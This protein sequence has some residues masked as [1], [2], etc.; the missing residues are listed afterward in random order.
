MIF[1]KTI[2][3]GVY[4]I[5]VEPFEDHRG[6][7]SRLYCRNEFQKIGLSKSLAQ[8][9]L[10]QTNIRGSVRGLHMQK[11][12]HAEV[13]IVRCLRG[14]CFDV[15]VDMRKESPTYLQWHGEM[16]SAENRR[17]LFIPEGFAHG[18]QALEDNTDLMYFVSEFYTPGAEVG[19]RYN[20]PAIGIQWPLE[21]INVSEKD[22]EHPLLK[23]PV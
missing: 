9:N 12:A 5:D 13:K 21:A 23:L 19:V 18:F 17:A 20:D 4:R 22:L 1:T 10:S 7:F 8:I 14:A 15:A 16:L 2:L 6:A 3:Q 11:D